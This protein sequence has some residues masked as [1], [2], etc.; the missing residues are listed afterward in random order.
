MLRCLPN[1][2]PRLAHERLVG[3]LRVVERRHDLRARAEAEPQAGAELEVTALVGLR[4]SAEPRSLVKWMPR[5]NWVQ[6][7]RPSP[8]T[9]WWCWIQASKNSS[10]APISAPYAPPLRLAEERRVFLIAGGA[11]AVHAAAVKLAEQL[12]R[13]GRRGGR[14]RGHDQ[15]RVQGDPL[16]RLSP[17]LRAR[18]TWPIAQRFARV[19]WSMRW[20][21]VLCVALGACGDRE[22]ARLEKIKEAVC[23][24]KT[25]SCAELALKDVPKDDVKATRRSQALAREMLDVHGEAVR[26]RAPLD[27]SRRD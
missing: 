5:P 11:L 8:L 1:A 21:L 2:E 6:V 9:Y 12:E 17:V 25:S 27:R 15:E 18:A 14:E 20:L 23:A 22:A 13:I 26:G 19:R 3:D 10:S 16:E 24:C 4:S 7:L